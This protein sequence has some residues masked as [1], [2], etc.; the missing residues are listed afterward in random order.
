MMRERGIFIFFK[1]GRKLKL[2]E[3]D[4][5]LLTFDGFKLTCIQTLRENPNKSV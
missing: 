4:A 5:K 1:L 3:S 2:F